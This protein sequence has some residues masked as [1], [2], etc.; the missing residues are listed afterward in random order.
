MYFNTWP[1]LSILGLS[2]WVL[3]FLWSS[4]MKKKEP[5]KTI[6][7]WTFLAICWN[8]FW[9]FVAFFDLLEKAEKGHL[10]TPTLV[11]EKNT[12]VSKTLVP[13]YAF[14]EASR[15]LPDH[16]RCLGSSLMNTLVGR[17]GAFKWMDLAHLLLIIFFSSVRIDPHKGLQVLLFR[18]LIE[19]DLY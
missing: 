12:R 11:Y 19:A 13:N 6:P 2:W 9:L 14:G 15:Y 5:I 18:P 8:T 3:S 4:L 7:E 17:P 1:K 10:E 16:F